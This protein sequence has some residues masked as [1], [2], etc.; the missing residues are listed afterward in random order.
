MLLL[1]PHAR[2]AVYGEAARM[3]ACRA[4]RAAVAAARSVAILCD[5]ADHDFDVARFTRISR[6]DRHAETET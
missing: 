4:M 6:A 2:M 5:A 1:E 3:A